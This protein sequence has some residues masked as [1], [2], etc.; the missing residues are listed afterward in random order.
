MNNIGLIILAGAVSV[1][2]LALA[3]DFPFSSPFID[4]A[5]DAVNS[6]IFYF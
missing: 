3:L 1:L 5:G 4:S 2:A 6:E